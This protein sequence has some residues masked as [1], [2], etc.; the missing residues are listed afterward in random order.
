MDVGAGDRIAVQIDAVH[1]SAKATR[2]ASD[3]VD[4]AV[5]E[6]ACQAGADGMLGSA[7]ASLLP[8]LGGDLS[9]ALST[10]RRAASD[11][12]SA[13]DRAAAQFRAD[14]D[15]RAAANAAVGK[16]LV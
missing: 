12:A 4:P 7:S 8:T 11:Y 9:D 5:A 14:E 15:K 10:W 6:L 13:L 3:Q 2:S 1:A 16:D